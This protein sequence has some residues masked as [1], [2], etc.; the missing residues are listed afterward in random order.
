MKAGASEI[1]IYLILKSKALDI[2]FDL[3]NDFILLNISKNIN[4]ISLFIE[5]SA[6]L[7]S[8]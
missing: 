3:A 6:H 7:L 4:T 8:M 1:L 5:K 2:Y